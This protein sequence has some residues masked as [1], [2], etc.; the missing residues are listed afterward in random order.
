MADKKLIGVDLGGTTIKF[1]ILTKDGE[2]Q[3]KWSIETNVLNEGQMIIPSI[4]DSINHHLKMYDMTADQFEGIGMGSP[5]TINFEEGSV[6]GAYNLN[7]ATKP[8]FPVRDISE[9]TGIPVVVENDAN[10]AA[11]GE[12]WMGAGNNADDVIFVTL[13]TGVGGGIIA[14]GKLIHGTAGAGGEIGHITVE[15]NGFMCTCGKRGC[16]E[17]IA[18][19]TGIVQVAREM[20][21][22]YAGPSELKAMLD[23]GQ[24]ISAKD[25]FDLAKK[26]DDLALLVANHVC[27]SLGFAL[28]NLS[29]ALNPKYV[30][31]GGGVSAAGDFLLEKVE[32]S[33]LKNEFATV[34]NS[35]EVRLASLGNGAGVIGAA[36]LINNK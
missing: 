6:V 15:P 24:D 21:A 36:S 3:Q 9:G 4:I 1:A 18:S 27:D 23:D 28:A 8:V 25:V 17:T 20:A 7:W 5:G 31:I 22:E 14:N 30:I 10:V 19:A 11:L 33:M 29:N 34:K 26:D 13:G 16:L 35:T 12:K 32:K 2:I